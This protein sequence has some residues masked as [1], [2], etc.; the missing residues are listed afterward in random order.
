MDSR[1]KILRNELKL[2]Q[3]AFGKIIGISRDAV[4]NLENGR[5]E[6]K[7]LV[8]KMM[9]SEFKVNEEWLRTGEGEMFITLDEE[10]A[11][12]VSEAFLKGGD[13]YKE[14]MIKVSKMSEKEFK[15]ISDFAKLIIESKEK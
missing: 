4:N 7:D 6:I 5:A 15:L 9:C 8:V 11:D 12:I 2:S 1:I 13:E 10:F 3:T 14:L